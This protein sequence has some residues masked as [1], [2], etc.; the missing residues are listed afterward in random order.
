MV[1]ALE[2]LDLGKI[3]FGQICNAA[4]I[5]DATPVADTN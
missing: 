4:Q 2:E 3:H 5:E 1:K